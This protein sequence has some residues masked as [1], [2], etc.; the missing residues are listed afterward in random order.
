M[1][2][3]KR[4]AREV[5]FD[6]KKIEN[7]ILKA[8][9]NGSGIVRPQIADDVALEI[10]KD[11]T[12]ENLDEVEIS[13]IESKVF[14]KLINKG[15]RLTAKAYEGYRKV[16][17][18]QRDSANTIDV[19]LAEM[20]GGTSEHW[21][22]ENSN[23]NLKLVTTQR[24]YMAGITSI[25]MSRRFLLSPDVV[26]AHDDGLI[27]FHDMDYFGQNALHNCFS[28]DTKLITNLGVKRFDEF[29]DGNQIQVK[30][31]DGKWRNAIVRNYGKQP[32]FDV[33]LKTPRSKCTVTCTSNHRWILKDGSVTTSLKIGDILYGTKDTANDYHPTSYDEKYWFC[34]GFVLGDGSDV[35]MPNKEF[36]S[37]KVRLCGNK[38][39][40]LDTFL[41]SG[42]E[43]SKEK[44]SNDDNCVINKRGFSKKVFIENKCWRLLTLENK[45]ALF[46]GYY[47]ADGFKDRYGI[48]TSNSEMADMIEELSA[49]SGYYITSKREEIRDT[50]YKNNSKLI[51]YRFFVSQPVNWLWKVVDIQPHFEKCNSPISCWCVEEPITHTF[52]LA[53]GVVTGNCCLINLED[54]LQNGTVVNG[55]LIEKPHK[56]STACTIATQIITAVASSQYGGCTISLTH[57]APFVKSSYEKFLKKYISW[58]IDEET[59]KDYA[60]KDTKTD[61]KDGVQTFNYQVNSMSTTNG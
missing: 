34:Y 54:M 10:E 4:D 40:W 6:R 13:T 3:I 61:I 12:Y 51:T 28:G 27:H 7:A 26:Q 47:A 35:Y 43:L 36:C 17:E 5:E 37:I 50:N 46:H 15:E 52:T 24:D 60:I 22:D 41:E 8:M 33:T 49:L 55:K 32:M 1:K 11:F 57:L 58:G 39:K 59:A 21:K 18:F 16:R 23:K 19:E 31:K 48:A 30:D 56:F 53:N 14:N 45:I 42:Y 2:V 38:N 20:L 29:Y 44:F 9:K 25:D